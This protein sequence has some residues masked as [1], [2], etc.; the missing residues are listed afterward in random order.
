MVLLLPPH[1]ILVVLEGLVHD[2]APLS[3]SSP[4]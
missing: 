1:R 2:L 4:C 3:V